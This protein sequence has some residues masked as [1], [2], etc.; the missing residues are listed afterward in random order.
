VG[1]R[2]V[3]VHR[4]FFPCHVYCSLVIGGVGWSAPASNKFSL[5]LLFLPPRRNSIPPDAPAICPPARRPAQPPPGQNG[6]IVEHFA[7]MRQVERGRPP[8]PM[9]SFLPSPMAERKEICH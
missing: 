2:L 6:I 1:R 9:A 8:P 7:V 5:S 4:L 3:P